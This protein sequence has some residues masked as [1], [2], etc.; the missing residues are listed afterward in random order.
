M[1]LN[2]AHLFTPLYLSLFSSTSRPCADPH[3]GVVFLRALL[4][5]FFY[6]YI[7]RGRPSFS[8]Q[9]YHAELAHS[10]RFDW[11][12]LFA[13]SR[14]NVDEHLPKAVRALYVYHT[15]HSHLYPLLIH[16]NLLN[17]SP[18][19]LDS[20]SNKN[21]QQS[22][23]SL[24]AQQLVRMHQGQLQKSKYAG[25]TANDKDEPIG[26]HQEFWSFDPFF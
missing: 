12:Q 14:Q 1:H 19:P 16:S 13:E 11:D 26:A 5:Q 21:H 17:P 6:Y 24:T 25:T 7:A 18:P 9:S 22:I 3:V 10:P 20:V 15:R 8:G 2:N 23:W 4:A